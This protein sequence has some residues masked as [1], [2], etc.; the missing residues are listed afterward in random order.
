MS[1]QK[2]TVNS[3]NL[4]NNSTLSSERIL[5]ASMSC[6]T[7]A[8][9]S[10]GLWA[11]SPDQT[12]ITNLCCVQCP[13]MHLCLPDRSPTVHPPRLKTPD[14]YCTCPLYSTSS[15]YR[16]GLMTETHLSLRY[17][18]KVLFL[19]LLLPSEPLI[20]VCPHYP[21][22]TRP[23]TWPA[24]SSP[25]LVLPGD[26]LQQIKWWIAWDKHL[27]ADFSVSQLTWIDSVAELNVIQDWVRQMP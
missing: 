27:W 21:W 10:V 3:V 6:A 8:T 22:Q 4:Y 16:W 7:A 23:E 14:L 9:D 20:V 24:H 13:G 5:T 19:K 1:I 25:S 15:T 12:A 26:M 2:K 18:V 17:W 11:K